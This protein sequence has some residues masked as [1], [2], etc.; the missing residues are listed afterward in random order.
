VEV[1]EFLNEASLH[2]GV[3]IGRGANLVLRETASVLCVLLVGRRDERGRQA[4]ERY[5]RDRR[6][7][8][9]QLDVND[10]ARLGYVRLSLQPRTRGA[11]PLPP[12]RRQ[13]SKRPR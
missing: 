11:H 5:G 10:E 3:I 12:G 8:E 6:A 1:E 2:G 4:M 9:H 7:A 13:H